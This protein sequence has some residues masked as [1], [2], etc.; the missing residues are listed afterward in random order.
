MNDV[1]LDHLGIGL[2]R[3][4]TKIRQGTSSKAKRAIEILTPLGLK[5]DT[6][7]AKRSFNLTCYQVRF[8]AHFQT[9]GLGILEQEQPSTVTGPVVLF[10]DNQ[11]SL[12]LAQPP[13]PPTNHQGSHHVRI[14]EHYVLERVAENEID[15][16]YIERVGVFE[17]IMLFHPTYDSRL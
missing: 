11:G 9:L 1:L 12:A 7:G 2:T 13:L 16:R 4:R 15:V 17:T 10:G 8:A 6:L 3:M 14:S 5:K